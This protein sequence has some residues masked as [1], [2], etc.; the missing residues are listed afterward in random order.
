MGYR[1]PEVEQAA[2][3]EDRAADIAAAQAAWRAGRAKE[4]TAQLETLP[5]IACIQAVYSTEKTPPVGV[6]MVAW[7]GSS[8]D[9]ERVLAEAIYSITARRR[10]HELFAAQAAEYECG[11]LPA[12]RWSAE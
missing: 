11:K 7:A 6:E 3:A 10:L 12:S 2:A 4:I 9:G 5:L 1:E 8:P